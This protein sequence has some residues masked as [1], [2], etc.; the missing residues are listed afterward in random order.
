M[1]LLPK[2]SSEDRSFIRDDGLR[3]AMI[4]NNVGHV[5]LSILSDL[6]CSGYGYEVGRLSQQSTMTH[7]ELYPREVRGKPTIKFIHMFSHFHSGMLKGHR[8]PVGLK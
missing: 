7:I 6:V 1:Q 8:F 3:D 5:E 4:A 2:V